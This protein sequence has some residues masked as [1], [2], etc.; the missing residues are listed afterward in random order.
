M[1]LRIAGLILMALL[2]SCGDEHYGTNNDDDDYIYPIESEPSLSPDHN[3]IYY[4]ST[5]T[6][7]TQFT[8][9]YRASIGAPIR[10]P[11]L[12]G[13]G[14]H[15]P[16]IGSDNNT[17]AYLDSSRIMFYR[18]SNASSWPSEIT[19]DFESIVLMDT[20]LILAQNNDSLFMVLGN[21][22]QYFGPGWDPTIVT[23]DTFI[24]FVGND[25][26][27][28]I[29]KNNIFNILPETL[30]TYITKAWLHW[31]SL[32]QAS[33]RLALD[34]GWHFQ[35]YIYSAESGET[36]VTYIDSSEYS[37]PLIISFDQII[38]TGPDGR[39]YVSPF[40]GAYSV[41]YVY[42]KE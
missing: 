36:S 1:N 19:R 25:S 39:F 7:Y 38:F 41:P 23:R 10:E 20:S 34:L 40:N 18:I 21:E 17:L 8:G 35:D 22:M 32:H 29:I 37:K 27:Y 42:V 24:Y 33:G 16:T 30:F 15:S 11:V 26:T 9:I 14:L 31:P 3:Y 5:D 13:E 4:I 12:M 6:N 28:H 2:L